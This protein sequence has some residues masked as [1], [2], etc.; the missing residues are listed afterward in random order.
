M[1]PLMETE[2]RNPLSYRI[3]SK[4][5]LEILN[6][7]NAEDKRV[8]FAVETAI[9]SIATIVDDVVASFNKGGRLFYIGAGT[10][11]RLGVL[12][13]SECPPTYGVDPSMVQGIIAGG[14]KALTTS[15]EWAED[16]GNAGI[17]TLKSH[18]F[19]PIDVLIGIT[20]SGGAPF[21]VEAMRYAKE[22]GAKVGAISCNKDTAVFDLIDEDHRI[23]VPVGPEIVTGSTRMKAGTAQKLVLNMITTTAM[24]R[25]GKVFNNLMVDLRPVN[26]KLILRSRRLIT[27]VTGC[28][29]ETSIELFE[30][31]GHNTKVAIT[32]GLLSVG[33]EEATKL[34]QLSEGS[35]SRV[36]DSLHS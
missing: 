32:M 15:V 1:K 10:S 18:D 2:Q 14:L 6:I 13:A 3:D 19:S 17:E 4:S 28:S 9:P 31:S 20:A 22:R 11:G 7:I 12:D 23:F 26:A 33:K 30:A 25:I 34:L 36:L 29:E 35:I 5:T 8:P 27:E 24:I 16:D 21:V